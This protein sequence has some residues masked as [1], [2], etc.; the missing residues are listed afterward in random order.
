M[1]SSALVFG[2]AH[3]SMKLA[4]SVQKCPLTISYLYMTSLFLVVFPFWIKPLPHTCM[5]MRERACGIVGSCLL[6]QPGACHI[7]M[8]PQKIGVSM[9][10]LLKHTFHIFFLFLWH[11]PLFDSHALSTFYLHLCYWMHL[12]FGL[13]PGSFFFLIPWNQFLL[14]CIFIYLSAFHF[15]DYTVWRYHDEPDT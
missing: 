2:P 7:M 6:L 8:T 11:L 14:L 12:N 9:S 13:C 5:H 4:S 3:F 10:E 1:D 15:A